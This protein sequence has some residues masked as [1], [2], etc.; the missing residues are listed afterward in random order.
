MSS[1]SVSF[2]KRWVPALLLLCAGAVHAQEGTTTTLTASPNPGE[3]NASITFTAQVTGNSG[4]TPSGTVTFT[5]VTGGGSSALCSNVSI[6][7]N[8]RTADCTVNNLDAGTYDIRADFTPTDSAAFGS[9]FDTLTGYV[10][11]QT[12]TSTALS[13]NP[14]SSVVGQSV[15][16]TAQITE[17]GA[18]DPTG[19]VQFEIVSVGTISGCSAVT[20]SAKEAQCT[21]SFSSPGNR[22]VRATYSG[23]TNFAGSQDDIAA[24]SVSK[25]DTTLTISPPGSSTVALNTFTVT[26][27]VTDSGSVSPTGTVDVTWGSDSCDSGP[28]NVTAGQCDITPS[29][30]ATNT[31]MGS[32]SGDS[33]FNSAT[34]N[35]E[36]HTVIK[37]DSTVSIDS[38]SPTTPAARQQLTI[39]VSVSGTGTETP[40]GTVMVSLD[41]TPS[42]SCTT[43]SLT[44]DGMGNG[45]GSCSLTPPESGTGF[46]LTASYAGDGNHNAAT[47][48]TQSVNVDEA[49]VDFSATKCATVSSSDATCDNAR[50]SVTPGSSL[51]YKITISRGS[52][53]IPPGTLVADVSDITQANPGVVTT[54]SA[55]GF[56]DGDPVTFSGVGGM[57][58]VNSIS[59]VVANATSTTFEIGD[60]SGFGSYTSGGTATSVQ[61]FTAT[62]SD[63]VDEV[64]LQDITWTICPAETD[65]DQTGDPD[66]C[67][68]EV[69]S[70]TGDIVDQTIT[71]ASGASVIGFVSAV[72]KSDASGSLS[73]SA[74]ISLDAGQDATDGT[75][76]NNTGTAGP[77]EAVVST[78]LVVSHQDVTSTIAGDTLSYTFTV[79]NTGFVSAD[80]V[81]VDSRPVGADASFI[82][83][84]GFVSGSVSWQCQAT[85][86][87]CCLTNG[88]ASQ[89]GATSPTS[90]VTA[91][92]INRAIDLPASSS[93]T[94]TVTGTVDPASTGSM[95]SEVQATLPAGIAD[96]SSTTLDTDPTPVANVTNITQATPGVVTTDVAH[97][98]SNGDLVTF[99]GV[100]GM[101]EVNGST[102]VV[103]NVASMTFEI[104]DTSGFSAYTSGGQ[105]ERVLPRT[106]SASDSIPI[107]LRGDLSIDKT[108]NGVLTDN[109]DGTLT[110]P[111]RIIVTNDGPSRVVG[112]TVEDL[113]NA[114]GFIPGSVSWN[115]DSG[116]AG[117]CTPASAMDAAKLTLKV[118]LDPGQ[119][120]GIDATA[121]IDDTTMGSVK[122]TATVAAPSGFTDPDPTNNSDSAEAT[123][124][125]TAD[126][127]VS[128]S[129]GSIAVP[130]EQYTY[131]VTVTND[132][133]DAVFRA[134]V[135]DLFP[136]EAESVSWTCE[137]KTPIPGG[138]TFISSYPG[139][140][141]AGAADVAVSPDDQHVFAVAA[142]ADALIYYTRTAEPGT[143]FGELTPLGSAVNGAGGVTDMETPVDVAVSPD[144]R[145]V[146]V[147]A[148]SS[149]AI[150]L[151][152]RDNISS[153]QT[154]GNLAFQTSIVD[155]DLTGVQALAISADGR[156]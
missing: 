42:V 125:A 89:C 150:A 1:I 69:A 67:E 49:E 134:R 16:F 95:T 82:G 56:S 120:I 41:T 73:N 65:A 145:H 85:G 45:E 114:T 21:T 126:L 51:R 19:T 135:L 151:F 84:P 20:V 22:Q 96:T 99:S 88:S 86:G 58:E 34:D 4:G 72:V 12:S 90:P 70:G 23:D 59:Y 79:A 11:N 122:N 119:S 68:T 104:A 57:T 136:Y 40:S 127:T 87:A 78:D 53:G 128:V 75:T 98:L 152:L 44:D 7:G 27:T 117:D 31:L 129:G 156:H 39:N 54:S 123:L 5:D 106:E 74:V 38:L 112:A 138:L 48:A 103:G 132:G 101:T 60:T 92:S 143:G 76:G 105:V 141:L 121:K 77:F 140:N 3:Q 81:Q 62:L 142:S 8:P 97:G 153:S 32:Y 149:G 110:A 102:F 61:Y 2:F 36:S 147:A 33:N 155:S 116:S 35:T 93:V 25:A 137:A 154:F 107:N 43:M 108:V 37:A 71:L 9:S 30:V 109:M 113:F 18:G 94:F 50:T 83:I 10:V 17:S 148:E 144:G 115:C 15:V 46:T 47:D 63:D 64:L 55:H 146:Y 29:E 111:Y 52:D 130:G 124:S 80:A 13:A 28:V 131:G 24:Y 139:S 66:T 133:P 6:N 14:T 26:W 118:D 91:D 100:L